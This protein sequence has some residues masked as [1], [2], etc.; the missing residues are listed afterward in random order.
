[1]QQ[2][3]PQREVRLADESLQR[4]LSATRDTEDL[5]ATFDADGFLLSLNPAGFR[6]LE[7][8]P[9]TQLAQCRLHRFYDDA[10]RAAFIA[11]DLPA[12]LRQRVSQSERTLLSCNGNPVPCTQTLV[13][14][15][16]DAGSLAWFSLIAHDIRSLRAAEA[17]RQALREQLFQARKLELLG[18]MAGSV[19][20]DFNNFLSV[21]MGHAELGLMN[22]SADEDLRHDLQLILDTTLKAARLTAQLRDYGSRKKIE[23][24]LLDLNQLLEEARPLLVS[25]LGNG[26][27]LQLQLEEGLWL[28]HFDRTQLEQVLFN[29]ALN[30]RDAMAGNGT[31]LI[32]TNR[33]SG[34]DKTDGS[35]G[36]Q[37]PAEL[38][39]L[40]VSDTGCGMTP[41]I[42]AHIFDPFFT[43][44]P[45]GKGT[46][47]G[48]AVVHSAVT[49]NGSEIRV[50]STPGQGS[51][52]EVLIPAWLDAQGRPAQ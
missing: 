39:R 31:L 8:P 5:V 34:Q 42:Q 9:D 50:C 1:M 14:H 16:N 37:A 6:L 7:L 35:S 29:L 12:A 3:L 26:I 17:E 44:K 23:P 4:E 20:H 51:C 32:S 2:W 52:F 36:T 47:L 28:V 30:A 11:E 13:A 38:V 18:K 10:S 21:I 43:T 40:C 15:S 48:L 22:P 49:R 45:R 41:E 24:E 33:V 46:G 27:N 25:M 19:A